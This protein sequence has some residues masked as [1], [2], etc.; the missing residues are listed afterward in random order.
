M[1]V[2]DSEAIEMLEGR[3]AKADR[4]QGVL[5]DVDE[6]PPQKLGSGECYSDLL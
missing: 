6:P 4:G 3:L 1:F 5:G 2:S